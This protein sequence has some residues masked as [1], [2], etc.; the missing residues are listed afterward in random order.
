MMSRN[1]R[2]PGNGGIKQWA[3]K[4]EN[5]TAA[6]SNTSDSVALPNGA[7]GRPVKIKASGSV[8]GA[9]TVNIG[10]G[11]QIVVQVNPNAPPTEENIPSQ[12]FPNQVSTVSFEY[13]TAGAGF[14]TISVGFA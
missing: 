6:A 7:V 8:A 11:A 2:G 9:V 12:A 10:N 3:T 4:F 5:P 13:T 14:L 1:M